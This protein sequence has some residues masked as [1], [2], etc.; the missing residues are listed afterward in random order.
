MP[1]KRITNFVER[2]VCVHGEKYDYSL[3]EYQGALLKVKIICR[4]HGIFEQ[5]ASKHLE[6]QGC[7][8]CAK[9]KNKPPGKKP[10]LSEN[11]DRAIEIHKNKYDY[12]KTDFSFKKNGDKTIIICPEHGEFLQSLDKHINRGHGCST[13]SG[14]RKKTQEEFLNEVKDVHGELYDYSLSQYNG[15]E[16]KLT[17]ICKRHG[18]FCQTPHNHIIHKQ[19][20]PYC[21]HRISKVETEWLN[22]IGIP[23]DK[24]HRNVFIKLENRS[25]KADGYEPSIKTVYE[26]Y[27]DYYHGNPLFY[28]P[29]IINPHTKCTFGELYQ[30]TREKEKSISDAGLKLVCIWEHEWK[31]LRGKNG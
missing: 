22:Y 8:K 16:A 29:D 30:R 11:R 6:G 27:G 24:E 20:C 17:I 26:F 12:S 9:E 28:R 31:E 19:G 23:N 15:F 25:I 4:S 3:T 2:A 10:K 1:G 21:V 7:S 18:E 14:N 13:C 5:G